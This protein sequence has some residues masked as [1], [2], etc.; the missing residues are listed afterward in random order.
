MKV[1]ACEIVLTDK[2]SRQCRRS[3][4]VLHPVSVEAAFHQTELTV[5]ATKGI[6]PSVKVTKNNGKLPRPRARA[7]KAEKTGYC[8][9]TV[10]WEAMEKHTRCQDVVHQRLSNE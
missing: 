4:E 9:T 3:Y 2:S 10:T 5:V 6:R 7:R 8:S 1:S